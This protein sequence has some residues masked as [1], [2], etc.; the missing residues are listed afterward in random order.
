MGIFLLVALV[1]GFLLVFTGS[2]RCVGRAQ[3]DAEDPGEEKPHPHPHPGLVSASPSQVLWRERGQLACW[4][5]IEQEETL[6][7][8][9]VLFL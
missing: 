5:L 6:Y 9:V 8:I 7:F 4:L 3:S 2:E 1:N